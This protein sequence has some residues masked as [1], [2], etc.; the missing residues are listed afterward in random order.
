MSASTLPD[1]QP[2]CT[3]PAI[4]SRFIAA[5]GHFTHTAPRPVRFRRIA[6]IRTS[7]AGHRQRQQAG[8]SREEEGVGVGV[9]AP[10]RPMA[11]RREGR[12]PCAGRPG[13]YSHAAH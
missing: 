6:P 2:T 11:Q 12:W 9:T 3:Q 4:V 1:D 10:V 13:P 5:R 8:A 7:P